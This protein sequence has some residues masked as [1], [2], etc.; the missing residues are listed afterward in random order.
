MINPIDLAAIH[1]DQLRAMRERCNIHV[2]PWSWPDADWL[3]VPQY[4]VMQDN[5][6]LN[7]F[8]TETE[9]TAFANKLAREL[10]DAEAAGPLVNDW[11]VVRGEDGMPVRMER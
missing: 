8:R 9:A 2:A 6:I 10:V 3:T 11:T 7:V 4:A 5:E 1:A